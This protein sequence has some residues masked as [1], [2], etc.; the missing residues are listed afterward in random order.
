MNTL[1]AITLVTPSFNQAPFLE[2]TLQSVLNQGYPDL[3]Y[4]VADGGS[5]DGSKEIIQ[6]H[7]SNLAAW[8]SEPDRGQYEALNKGFARSSGAVMG[9]L[10]ADDLH[11][12]WTLRAVGEIFAQ[13]P[14]IEW[15][16]TT[17]PMTIRADDLPT[18]LS[19]MSAPPYAEAF[20]RGEC[21]ARP[22]RRGYLMQEGTFWRRDLWQAA[23]G[24]LDTQFKLAADFD[25]WARF[26]QQ[27]DPVTLSIP[28]AGFRRHG[29]NRSVLQESCY[30]EEVR[31][32]LKRHNRP[33]YSTWS[34]W[35][36]QHLAPSLTAFP[37]IL[38]AL[39]AWHE[40][41]YI[42]PSGDPLAPW[43][44]ATRLVHG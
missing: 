22:G 43:R 4:I 25:L 19:A 18:G 9:W 16:T 31:A 8:W 37:S 29:L 1:P 21:V 26:F 2:R 17:S 10:N 36:R 6:R 13:F 14:E 3:E 35:W 38:K 15:L 32:I 39:G 30:E 11:L 27:A 42:K 7:A 5:T 34:R 28:L 12:P 24:H 23:G 40:L 33:P 20:F 44:L 41:R